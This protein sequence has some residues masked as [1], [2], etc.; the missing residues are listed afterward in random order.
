[1]KMGYTPHVLVI[2]GGA[3]GTAVARDLAIRGLEVTLVEQGHLATGATGRM[4]GLLHSGARFALENQERAR[5]CAAEN[6]TLREIA[7]HCIEDTEGLVVRHPADDP[8]YFEAKREACEEA[9]IPVRD[10]S[11]H[12]L[13]KSEPNLADFIEHAF[14]VPDAVIDP[15]R[16][17]VATAKSAQEYGAVIE[18]H[19]E[20]T[21]VLVEDGA[22]TGA[23]IRTEE[24]T[25]TI[26]ADYIVNATGAW[27]GKLAEMAGIDVPLSL[28]QGAM[29]VMDDRPTDRV[30]SRCRPSAEGDVI[31]PYDGRCILGTTDRPINRPDDVE[32]TGEEVE[33]LIDELSELVPDIAEGR[34]LRS[35]WGVRVALQKDQD[36]DESRAMS[37]DF[38]VLDHE[39]RDGLWGMSTVVGGTL[40]THRLSAERVADQVCRKFGIRRVGQTGERA[41]PGSRDEAALEVAMEEFGLDSKV[42]SAS[43]DR[44]GS[45]AGEV[46]DTDGPNPVVCECENVTRAEIKDALKDSTAEQGDLDAV[47]NRTRAGMGSCQGGRCG[48]RLGS[49]LYL[50]IPHKEIEREVKDFY[51]ERWKGQRHALWGDQMAQAMENYALLATTM[52][53]DTDPVSPDLEDFD[54]G[55]EWDEDAVDSPGGFEP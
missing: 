28:S 50:D 31:V 14:A 38:R 1:M 27:A 40:T 55:P 23:Q 13:R 33:L 15:F 53:R 48:H 9:D 34:S 52:N 26:S 21:D 47:R 51:Q 37:E 11:T 10:L 19:T 45:R 32:E 18:T 6:D 12:R 3:T 5:A 39:E 36:S 2:G 54:G 43:E 41:L 4:Q 29:V 22:I 25:D 24:E 44:L 16:L 20:V 30:I 49:L 46:L 8:E 17:S 7:G 42:L 35:Y